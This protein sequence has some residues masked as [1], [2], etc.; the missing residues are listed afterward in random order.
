MSKYE[1]T[2]EIHE[3][4]TP[5][6]GKSSLYFCKGLAYVSGVDN[7]LLPFYTQCFI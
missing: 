7:L 5:Q 3:K 2:W 6:K 4:L 1:V